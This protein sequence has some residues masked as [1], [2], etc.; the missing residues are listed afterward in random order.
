MKR[1]ALLP[2]LSAA[3]LVLGA[4]G[5][6]PALIAQESAPSAVP[7]PAAAAA[8]TGVFRASLNIDRTPLDR[9][10]PMRRSY[11]GMLEKVQPAVVTV[12]TGVDTPQRT[13]MSRD[14]ALL[15][16]YMGVPPE[17]RTNEPKGGDN[18]QQIGLGTGVIVSKSGY[19][20]TNRH[21]VIP[22]DTGMAFAQLQPMLHIKIS[23][24][25]REA[26]VARVEVAPG[27]QS[28]RQR[29]ADRRAVRQ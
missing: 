9:D 23:V 6:L 12:L 24:P 7:A 1:P 10:A 11:A 14:E 4:A 17:P 27:A 22:P 16:Y 13:R 19:I 29:P 26:V 3:A 21:V 15:R 25:G 8:E 28:G 18:W 5:S 20:L 2:C